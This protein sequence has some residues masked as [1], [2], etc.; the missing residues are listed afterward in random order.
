MITTIN[1]AGGGERDNADATSLPAES[2]GEEKGRRLAGG[3]REVLHETVGAGACGRGVR[4]LRCL[5]GSVCL[6][7]YHWVYIVYWN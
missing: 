2:R 6:L 5:A 4:V 7:G 3:E 1:A